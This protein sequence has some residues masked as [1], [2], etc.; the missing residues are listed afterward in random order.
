M[1]IKHNGLG[2]KHQW[3]IQY[4]SQMQFVHMRGQSWNNRPVHAARM[5]EIITHSQETQDSVK[6][7]VGKGHTALNRILMV[8]LS[9][10]KMLMTTTSG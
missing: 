4:T 5:R 9:C 3:L 10:E 6:H 2:R 8:T 7:F 1:E